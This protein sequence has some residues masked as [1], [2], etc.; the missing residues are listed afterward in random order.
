MFCIVSAAVCLLIVL[1]K[2]TIIIV[3]PHRH[4]SKLFLLTPIWRATENE[5][6]FA[7]ST[8]KSIRPYR[9]TANGSIILVHMAHRV[10]LNKVK[11]FGR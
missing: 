8:L 6:E 4:G 10:Q 5:L 1:N 3:Q 7:V 9:T 2:K 11:K